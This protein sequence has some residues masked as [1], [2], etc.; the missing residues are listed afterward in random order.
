M[1]KCKEVFWIGSGPEK[2]TLVKKK[3]RKNLNE[4]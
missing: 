2:V 3:E 4:L 1:G